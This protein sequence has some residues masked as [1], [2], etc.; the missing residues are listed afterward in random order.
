MTLTPWFIIKF[1]FTC[2]IHPL[3]IERQYGIFM[4]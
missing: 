4:Y 1:I 2:P 3:L